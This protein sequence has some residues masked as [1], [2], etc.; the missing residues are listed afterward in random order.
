MKRN[1]LLIVLVPLMVV[2]CSIV[3]YEY[4]Y[5]RIQEEMS[6][7]KD[8]QTVKKKTLEKYV[9]LIAEKPS[10]EQKLA[11]LTEQRKAEESKLIIGETQALGA[12]QLQ[13]IVKG[14]IT[15]RG[16]TI[17]SERVGKAEELGKFK[18]ITVSIDT[19]LP[20][21]RVLGDVLY[22]IETRTPHLLVKEMDARVRNFREPKE[23]M[24]K[25]DVVALYGGK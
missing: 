18:I 14:I 24:V 5:L 2:L 25:F 1:R 21:I 16:G 13:E 3:A 11:S 22:S 10:L 4:G 6:S 17:S 20:D 23:L 7:I 9:S 15:S 19:V 8:E 12:A